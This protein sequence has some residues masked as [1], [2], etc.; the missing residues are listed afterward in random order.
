[1]NKVVLTE[2]QKTKEEVFGKKIKE[3]A[4]E[5]YEHEGGRFVMETYRRIAEEGGEVDLG[6]VEY[7]N[8]LVAGT[9]HCSIHHIMDNYVYIMLRNV[10]ELEKTKSDLEKTN[11]ELSEKNIKLAQAADRD[12][13]YSK[14]FASN[15]AGLLVIDKE[16][17]IV[18]C[19][20]AVGRIFNF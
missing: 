4:P 19:N 1:M 6:L 13:K 15:T 11:E 2:M 17:L 9:Y 16:S 14:I 7:S 12:L 3:V 8:H 18:E 10:T 5:A 20:E